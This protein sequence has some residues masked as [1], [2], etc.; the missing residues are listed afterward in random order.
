MARLYAT[1]FPDSQYYDPDAPAPETYTRLKLRDPSK[2]E[3]GPP[4]RFG[5]ARSMA[6][7]VETLMV[8]GV[9]GGFAGT[10]QQIPEDLEKLDPERLVR[11]VWSG[12]VVSS[13]TSATPRIRFATAAA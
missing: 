13:S 9:S 8:S 10:G 2:P 12:D 4:S 7:L 1:S 11:A 6:P 3:P 5:E